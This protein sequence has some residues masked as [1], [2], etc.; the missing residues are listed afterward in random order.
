[1]CSTTSYSTPSSVMWVLSARSMAVGWYTLEQR[2]QGS[3]RNLFGSQNKTKMPVFPQVKSPRMRA[4]VRRLARGEPEALSSHEREVLRY[5]VRAATRSRKRLAA[6]GCW[7]LR[8][9]ASARASARSSTSAVARSCTS[10]RSRRALWG[11][12]AHPASLPCSDPRN[13]AGLLLE[14]Y[15]MQ[16]YPRKD[17]G[18]ET[19]PGAISGAQRTPVLFADEEQSCR[20]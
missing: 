15:P 4:V 9:S 17:H 13:L 2:S 11:G 5:F 3:W 1:M 18:R 20:C 12:R 8:S 19:H 7:S 16:F 6:S 10:M 14:R